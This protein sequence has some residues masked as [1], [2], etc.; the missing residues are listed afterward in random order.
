MFSLFLFP[1]YF[2]SFYFHFFFCLS[3]ASVFALMV[4]SVGGCFL[5][6]F[7]FSVFF[8]CFVFAL[9]VLLRSVLVVFLFF[10]YFG[11]MAG[12]WG[13]LDDK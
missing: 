5:P 12:R 6:R 7:L 4:I 1:F 11:V 13:W 10:N 3:H 8:R 9:L 2:F